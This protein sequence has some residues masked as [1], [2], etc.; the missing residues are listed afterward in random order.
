MNVQLV[1]VVVTAV[2]SVATTLV[3]VFLGP[4]WKD[5]VDSQRASRQRSEQLLARYS[6]PLSRAAFDLQSRL[7]NICRQHFLTASGIPAP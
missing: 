4:A 6:E 1:T 2:V 7:Y 3:V 5:R